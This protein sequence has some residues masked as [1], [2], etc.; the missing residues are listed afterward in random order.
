MQLCP[1][2][3]NFAS[4]APVTAASRSASP[5][6]MKGALPPSSSSGRTTRSLALLMIRRPTSVEPVKLT[7]RTAGWA[8]SVS[9]TSAAGP[10]TRLTTPG[11]IPASSR[12]RIISTTASGAFSEARATTGQPAARAGASLRAWMETG[13]FHGVRLATTPA[14]RRMV[15]CRRPACSCGWT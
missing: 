4:I 1:P 5:K 2:L 14:G 7:T 3:R 6:T 8:S 15:R 9:V 11:G 10:C 13:K 12:Q